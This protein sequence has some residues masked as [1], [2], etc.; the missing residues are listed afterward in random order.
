MVYLTDG[1]C[2]PVRSRTDSVYFSSGD[3]F[4]RLPAGGEIINGRGQFTAALRR[5]GLQMIFAR[6][7]A[8]MPFQTDTSSV[9]S[10]NPGPFS[11]LLIILPGE[12][13]LPGD[14]ASYGWITPGKSGTPVA[15]FVHEP[16]AVKVYPCDRCWNRVTATGL[17]VALH[18]EFAAEFQPA[19]L[20][21]GDSAVFS[22]R[23]FFPGSNQDIWVADRNNQY[24]S[25]RTRLE[26]K[27]RGSRL[28]ILAPDTVFAGETAYIRVVVRDAND[29]PVTA[30]VCR[31]EV[32]RGSGEMLDQA[33]LTDTLGLVIARFLCTRARFGEFDTIR[34]SS[35]TAE[36]LISIYVNIPD[37]SL[38]A[39]KIV[40]FPNPFGF[41]RD[42]AEI[43]YY[44]NRSSPIDIRIY[45]PF[46]NEVFGSTFRQGEPGARAGIN[47]VI[48]DGRNQSGRRVAS[49]VYVVQI[50][51]QLHTGTTFKSTYR[52]G[53]VW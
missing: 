1:W 20:E 25:Y 6:P 43:Y 28:E 13:H 41:N 35:G 10:V 37:S 14:T 15:Q 18:S 52:L 30:A 12:E 48:W 49:G 23:Y 11:Q 9:I 50:I 19:E 36:S 40:A 34:I 32:V 39:G 3:S 51:G 38:L 2:N 33:L 24:V 21:L 29:Q 7:A 45:D 16:F 8:G 22:A 31:F 47:R 5:A 27:A 46:G 44:L 26:I 42:A 53:V 17:P 4:A